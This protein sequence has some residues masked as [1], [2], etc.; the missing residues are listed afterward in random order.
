M[1]LGNN[2]PPKQ[3]NQLVALFPDVH[4]SLEFPRLHQLTLELKPGRLDIEA[5][6]VDFD[7]NIQD[8]EGNTVLQWACLRSD[9]KTTEWLLRHGADPNIPNLNI[10]RTPLMAACSSVSVPCIKML[11]DHGADVNARS[12]WGLD[13]M[14]YLCNEHRNPQPITEMVEMAK[15]FISHG[16]DLN[17]YGDNKAWCLDRAARTELLELMELIVDQGVDINQTINYGMTALARSITWCKSRSAEFLLDKGA[18]YTGVFERDE[19]GRT[20]L[21]HAALNPNLDIVKVLINAKLEGLNPDI[22]DKSGL[23]AEEYFERSSDHVEGLVPAF[24]Q[25]ISDI[26]ARFLTRGLG[27]N[28]GSEE[29]LV[30]GV[31]VEEEEAEEFFDALG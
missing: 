9:V 14:V 7:I 26:R 2:L 4:S 20:L 6:K 5:T 13:A 15:L 22:C 23:K 31:N 16:I 1:I 12:Q 3:R 19:D 11:L 30:D 18:A 28:C 21:H 8:K 29:T 24:R 10:G 25:L 17:P 27:R